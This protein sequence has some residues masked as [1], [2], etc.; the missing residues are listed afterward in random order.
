MPYLPRSPDL[1][2]SD[3]FLSPLLKQHLRD[4]Q[5]KSADYIKRIDGGEN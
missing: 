3:F 4:G 1:A 5:Y 2:S